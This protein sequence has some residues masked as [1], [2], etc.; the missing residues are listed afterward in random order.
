MG[1]NQRFHKSDVTLLAR[2]SNLITTALKEQII[3]QQDAG[4]IREFMAELVA[5]SQ[6]TAGRQYKLI[7]M[8][9]LNRA[10]LP[11]Y[12]ECTIG[13]IYEAVNRLKGAID[14]TGDPL[15][16]RNT[17]SDRVKMIKRFFLWLAENGYSEV[18]EKKIRKIKPPTPDRMTKTVDMLLSPNEIESLIRAGTN[19]RDRALLAVLYEGGFRIGEIGNLTWGQLKFTDWN[20]AVNTAEKTGKP[21]FIPLVL[22]RA[23]L[24]QWKND[25]P[26]ELHPDAF[27]FLTLTTRKPIQY[28]NT[29]KQIRK[30]AERA[31]IT[32][33]IT[34]HIFRHSRI[35]HLIQQGVPETVIKLMMWG[36]LTTDMFQT[37]AHLT[38]NDVEN[39]IAELNGIERSE[40][41]R[42]TR[43]MKPLQCPR[44]AE[45]NSPGMK[46]CGKCGC[47]LSESGKQE[48][49]QLDMLLQILAKNPGMIF[50]LAGRMENKK[51]I[52]Q[53]NS[54]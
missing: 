39:C 20:V 47:S 52:G 6:L 54:P 18:D 34:P 35:T 29:V 44:C 41:K 19:S 26:G 16:K 36:N 3:S 46:F 31:G 24:A 53:G 32:K 4:L 28:Q 33:H 45:I 38:N 42:Q 30:L 22:S 40:R 15:F 49:E 21:R 14:E 5:S 48:Q 2:S 50:E 9:I 43:A 25:Y 17:I 23:Y 27:V 7:N 8:M 1:K 37:Y 13:D 51:T 12:A 11:P 10:Y